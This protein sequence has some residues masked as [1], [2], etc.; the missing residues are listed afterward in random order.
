MH[1]TEKRAW[2]VVHNLIRFI[3]ENEVFIIRHE[4]QVLVVHHT[5]TT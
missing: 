2:M 4:S 5:V 3:D 1:K